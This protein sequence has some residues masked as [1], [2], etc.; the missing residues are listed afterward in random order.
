M[1]I[2]FPGWIVGPQT[3][4]GALLIHRVSIC[5]VLDVGLWLHHVLLI[6][7]PLNDLYFSD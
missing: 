6:V 5:S 2:K 4:F 3:P 1:E 7:L